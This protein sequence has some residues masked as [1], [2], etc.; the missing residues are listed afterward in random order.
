MANRALT[1]SPCPGI[2]SRKFLFMPL[3]FNIEP[4]VLFKPELSPHLNEATVILDLS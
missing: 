2:F 1:V 4:Y 3:A